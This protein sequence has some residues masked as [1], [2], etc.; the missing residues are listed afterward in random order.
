MNDITGAL[1][2][3]GII[4]KKGNEDT[5]IFASQTIP[6][7]LQLVPKENNLVQVYIEKEEKVKK[8]LNGVHGMGNKVYADDLENGSISPYG[9]YLIHL[10]SVAD[11]FKMLEKKSLIDKSIEMRK[12]TNGFENYYVLA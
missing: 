11:I 4:W 1:E 10:V 6:G 5:W 9:R 3:K 12:I 2:N 8:F 7:K